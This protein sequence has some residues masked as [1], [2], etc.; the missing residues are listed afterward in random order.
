MR[1]SPDTLRQH[2]EHAR[3]SGLLPLF[4]ASCR[5]HGVALALALALASRES[6][7]GQRPPLTSA[8]ASA[9][10][11]DVG[12]M[13]LNRRAHPVFTSSHR[14]DDHAANIEYGVRYLASLLRR[15]P[16]N[17]A[18]AV[19]AYN[20]GPGRVNSAVRAGR[21]PD[22]VTT[23][24]DYAADVLER[25]ASI[26]GRTTS[27]ARGASPGPALSWG[28]VGMVAGAVGVL[29]DPTL[30][31]LSGLGLGVLA[32]AQADGRLA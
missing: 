3:R 5:R 30:G 7:I 20:A 31:A 25:A 2:V 14:N 13:Q 12:V 23:G 11:E 26:G 19:A 28:T 6:H 4:E 1:V 27:A 10:G 15:F 9:N 16:R 22:S 32:K 29:L 24:G 17:A 21:S 18:A 8:W